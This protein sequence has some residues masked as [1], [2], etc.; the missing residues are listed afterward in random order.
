MAHCQ[1][2]GRGLCCPIL[3]V[4]GILIVLQANL[5]GYEVRASPGGSLLRRG[6][7]GHVATA[8]AEP[9]AI[10][11]SATSSSEIESR[12]IAAS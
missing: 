10:A 8:W 9:S 2:L 7:L 6:T 12:R 3:A 11:I 1:P 4:E 5:S